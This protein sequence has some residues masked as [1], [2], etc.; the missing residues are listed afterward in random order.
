MAPRVVARK[1]ALRARQRINQRGNCKLASS[2]NIGLISFR[3]GRTAQARSACDA[4]DRGGGLCC[5]C[6]RRTAACTG[7]DVRPAGRICRS[8]GW[9]P[10]PARWSHRPASCCRRLVSLHRSAPVHSSGFSIAASWARRR[11]CGAAETPPAM[12]MPRA[13]SSIRPPT[14]MFMA[15]PTRDASSMCPLL[16]AVALKAK[17]FLPRPAASARSPSRAAGIDA[18][19]PKRTAYSGWMPAALM[20]AP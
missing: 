3:C 10:R 16:Q 1:P 18:H 7:C 4:S 13:R 15:R 9:Q 8:A 12:A 14:R 11:Q 17:P 2:G 19:P 5:C 20:I 6:R